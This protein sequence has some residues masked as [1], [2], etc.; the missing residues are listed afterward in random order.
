MTLSRISA[1][2]LAALLTRSMVA[3][4]PPTPTPTPT[5]HDGPVLD[6]TFSGVVLFLK[7]RSGYRVIVPARQAQ[8]HLPYMIFPRE[9]ATSNWDSVDFECEGFF[10]RVALTA[11]KLSIEPVSSIAPGAF[12]ADAI[13]GWLPHLSALVENNF[14]NDDD[15]NQSTPVVGKVAAQIDITRGTLKPLVVDG[16]DPLQWE[17][18]SKDGGQTSN[19]DKFCGAAGIRW[20]LPIKKDIPSI[21]IGSS[22]KKH[23]KVTVPLVNG[24]TTVVVIG[25]SMV[26][27]IECPKGG[28]RGVVDPDFAIHYKML[29]TEPATAWIPYS[30]SPKVT[31]VPPAEGQTTKKSRRGSDCIGAQFP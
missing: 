11:D 19:A 10:K 3:S 30:V 31:C 22:L 27:D 7:T 2:A 23:P 16:I 21:S 13:E 18:R 24:E 12:K 6:I 28:G 9:G 26:E 17:F 8:K 14:V 20:L 29:K 1:L 5:P 25:N 15:Y 4:P